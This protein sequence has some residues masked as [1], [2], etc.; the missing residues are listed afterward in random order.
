MNALIGSAA[1]GV[2]ACRPVA[3]VGFSKSIQTKNSPNVRSLKPTETE[4]VSR[5]RIFCIC[6][7]FGGAV[8]GELFFV[9]GYYADN[10]EGW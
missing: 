6:G 3:F 5:G 10:K 7:D 4:R 1:G 2:E 8:G 9:G